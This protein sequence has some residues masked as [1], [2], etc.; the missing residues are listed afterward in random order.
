MADF[1]VDH[2]NPRV[3]HA[4]WRALLAPPWHPPEMNSGFQL[5]VD[6]EL[7]GVY[8]AIYS[9]RSR[10][11]VDLV[12]CNLGAFCVLESFRSHSL[13]L[14]RAVLGQKGMLFTD[15]SP[16]GNVPAMNERLGF[17]HL[18]TGA[19]VVLNRPAFGGAARVTAEPESVASAVSGRDEEVYRDHL[20]APAARHLV[21]TSGDEYAYMI[22]R[23]DTR[24]RVRSFASP[25]YVGG[26]P[27]LLESNWALVGAHL[28]RRG[29]IATIAERR[30]LGFSP[31]GWGRHVAQPRPK[32]FKGV[33]VSASEVDYLYSELTLLEW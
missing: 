19:R 18:D 9:R 33:G 21:V 4:A 28:L 5:R 12:V 7:V 2:L 1:L 14:V 17:A 27:S 3:S 15:L 11:G 13:R 8:V 32:M 24:K 10:D 6:G 20:A 23:R 30:V 16:S 26:D 31:A 22:Y 29:M 25:L